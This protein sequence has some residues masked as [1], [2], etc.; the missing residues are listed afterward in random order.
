MRGR[1]GGVAGPIPSRAVPFALVAEDSPDPAD[2]AL[3][4]EQVA[5]AAAEA[6]EAG[7]AKEFGIFARDDTGHVLAGVSGIVWGG[8]CELNALWVDEGLRG[9]GLARALMTEAES[10]A[11]T[12]GC[13]LILFHAYD[14]LTCG[15]Y[16]RLGCDVVGVV[17]GVPA[18]STA[19]WY[20]KD[21]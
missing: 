5:I 8:Y 4:E 20:R 7:E 1:P 15:L 13:A 16:E 17:E 11:R 14:A 2:L 6:V 9:R 21:L 10:H 12:K 3:L 19:R 18:G